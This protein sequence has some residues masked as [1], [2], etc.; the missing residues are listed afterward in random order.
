[1][2]AG[3]PNLLRL[4]LAVG[5]GL[6]LVVLAGSARADG[7]AL[8]G[9]VA[10]YGFDEGTGSAA[11]DA[12]GNGHT[13]TISGATWSNSG[14]YGGALSFDG[15]SASVLLGSLGT[16]YQSGF[17]LDAWVQKQSA[18]RNDVGIVGTWNGSSGGPMLWVDHLATRYHLTL[19]SGIAN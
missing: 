5:L 7:G 6:S 13:G 8:P 16:F 14:R 17:T 15:N 18:T 2:R 9:L 10:A 12:S 3:I 19:G 11:T 4:V 1:M